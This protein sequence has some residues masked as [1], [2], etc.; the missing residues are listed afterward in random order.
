MT[1]YL[2]DAA[3]IAEP[4]TKEKWCRKMGLPWETSPTENGYQVSFFGGFTVWVPEVHFDL[5]FVQ[6]ADP[7]STAHEEAEVVTDVPAETPIEVDAETAPNPSVS[8][9]DN[10][11]ESVFSSDESSIQTDIA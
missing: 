2:L 1:Q 10:G 3:V 6:V 11:T 8:T 7:V 9:E 5:N 4:I